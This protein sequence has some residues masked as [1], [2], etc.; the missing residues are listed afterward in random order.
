[1]TSHI[2]VHRSQYISEADP[3]ISIRGGKLDFKTI[4]FKKNQKG[5]GDEIVIIFFFKVIMNQFYALGCTFIPK[6]YIVVIFLILKLNLYL[7]TNL[8]KAFFSN[9]TFY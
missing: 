3:D 1:M 4:G 9:I 7:L 8:G 6:T 5:L 2:S